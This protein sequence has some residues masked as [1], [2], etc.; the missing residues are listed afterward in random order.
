[1]GTA[2]ARW[3]A[4]E[5][6]HRGLGRNPDRSGDAAGVPRIGAPA[7]EPSFQART[8]WISVVA[9]S[10]VVAGSKLLVQMPRAWVRLMKKGWLKG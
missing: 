2:D 4:S 1:L 9:G 10:G 5:V 8:Y 7:Q 6:A 3:L